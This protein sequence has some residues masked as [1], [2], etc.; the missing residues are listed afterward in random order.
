MKFFGSIIVFAAM[1]LT[2]SAWGQST[3]RITTI[4]EIQGNTQAHLTLYI[5]CDG[6]VQYMLNP[7][8]LT[9]TDNGKPVEEFSIVESSSPA[10]RN[11]FSAAI[12]LDASGSMSGAGNAG[13]K[14][15]GKAFVA[16]MDSVVDEAC[17]IWFNQSIN[18]AQQ[19]TTLTPLLTTAVDGLPAGGATAVW[20]AMYAGIDEISTNGVNPKQAVVVMTDGADNASVRSPGDV[21][22]YAQQKNIRVFT[23]GLGSAING[24]VLDTIATQTGGLYF[25]TPNASELQ[26]I[27]TEVANFMGRGFDEHTVAFKTPD[28]DATIHTLE[29]RVQACAEEATASFS[30]PALQGV[31]AVKPV[32][33]AA[34]SLS[35]EQNMP[36]PFTSGT[37]TSIPFTISSS[38]PQHVTLEVF[39]ILGRHIATLVDGFRAQGSYNVRF[40][41]EGL[42]SGMYLYRLSSG[43]VVTSRMMLVR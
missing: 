22:A 2:T 40:Q 20:D 34:A 27:F 36:N 11:N 17:V 16:F 31:T 26:Q 23:I 35:L 29:V 43:D 3:A 33:A 28:P 42:A 38:A 19:M 15:A 12:V 18:M 37:A 9:I 39:D 25:Q 8:D 21:I 30:E 24:Y 6:E 10:V 1:I 14:A 41:A 7:S 4:H 5:T 32:S 13:A